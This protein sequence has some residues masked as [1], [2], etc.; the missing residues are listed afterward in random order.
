MVR[1]ERFFLICAIFVSQS[2]LSV[3]SLTERLAV[4]GIER[5][6]FERGRAARR[7][8]PACGATRRPAF[9]RRSRDRPA[10]LDDPPDRRLSHSDDPWLGG[11]QRAAEP[12]GLVAVGLLCDRLCD[13]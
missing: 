9:H 10:A 7:V 13:G 2:A 8:E 12:A 4:Y 5:A 3:E 6:T 11:L 1:V